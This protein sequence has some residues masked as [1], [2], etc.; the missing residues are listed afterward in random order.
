MVFALLHPITR[1]SWLQWSIHPSTVIGLVALGAIY[2]WRAR[3]APAGESLHPARRAS[4]VAA[5][6]VIFASLNG[7]IHDLSDDYLFSAHM[8][9]HLLL[10]LVVPPLLIAG[11]PG[12]MLRPALRS[13]IVARVARFLTRPFTCYAVFNLVIIAW[14][15]PPMY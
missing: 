7:P 9:Q 14:H 11:T 5:L 13:R 12:W 8:V 1:V 6:L 15:L 3:S 4:F 10:T 2:S